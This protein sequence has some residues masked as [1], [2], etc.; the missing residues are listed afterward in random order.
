MIKITPL[1]N[2]GSKYIFWGYIGVK[3]IRKKTCL[4]IEKLRKDKT[5]K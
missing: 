2:K 5:R 3:K 1:K 4:K